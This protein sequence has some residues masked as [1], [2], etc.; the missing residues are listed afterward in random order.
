MF[1]FVLFALMLLA[2]SGSQ[3]PISI[4]CGFAGFGQSRIYYEAV[5]SSEPTV[6]PLHGDMLDCTMWDGQFGLLAENHRVIRYDAAAHG[7]PRLPPEAYL[8]HLDLMGLMTPS[9]PK[10]LCWWAI[11]SEAGSRSTPHWNTHKGWSP[12]RRV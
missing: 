1:L 9:T 11:H 10:R 8:D 4:E 2:G 12:C 7:R 6:I 3:Q 5:G